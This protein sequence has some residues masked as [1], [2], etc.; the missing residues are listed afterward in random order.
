MKK[1]LD[2]EQRSKTSKNFTK[3][4]QR[5]HI[6]YNAVLYIYYSYSIHYILYTCVT[7][8]PMGSF[9]PECTVFINSHLKCSMNKITILKCKGEPKITLFTNPHPGLIINCKEFNMSSNSTIITVS[10]KDN[11]HVEILASRHGERDKYN[12]YKKHEQR[13][14]RRKK[15]TNKIL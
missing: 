15:S 13:T 12:T 14:G 11:Y 2:V 4:I 3:H 5:H 7:I 9:L 10:T 6:R 1:R 8:L